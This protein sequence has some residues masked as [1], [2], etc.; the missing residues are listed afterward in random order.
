MKGC[1]ING[2]GCVATQKTDEKGQFIEVEVNTSANVVEAVQPSYKGLFP[3]AAGRRMAKGVKMGIYASTKA[4]EEANVEVPDAIITGTGMGCLKDSEKFLTAMIKNDEQFLTPT[5]FIQ[6]T[7][8]T[9]GG[10]IALGLKCN[11]YNF[12]YVNGAVSFESA[13]YDAMLQLESGEENSILIG[14]VDEMSDHTLELFK[15]A[16]LIKNAEDQPYDVLHPKSAGIV[17]GE[18]AAF[19]VVEGEKKD[20]SYAQVVDVEI[21]NVLSL[22]EVEDFI[23]NFLS[24]NDI[25]IADIDAVLLGNNGDVN[26]D[27]FYETPKELFKNS[28]QLYYKHLTGEWNTVSSVGLGIASQI[29]K[30]QKVEDFYKMNNMEVSSINNVLIYNQYRGIDHSLVLLQKC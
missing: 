9:V 21:R 6:S 11:G 2:L 14:G 23:H 25:E 4:L 8:N 19:F 26:Y 13:L 5:N 18:G 29:I 15:I 28:Q 12:T 1:Y 7:H 27:S 22:D 17:Q 3:P 30:N 16:K 20:T 24:D 10:Q